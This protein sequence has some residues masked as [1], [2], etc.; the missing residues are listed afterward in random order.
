[1]AYFYID[2]IITVLLF[3]VCYICCVVANCGLPTGWEH[4]G[5]GTGSSFADAGQ[6]RPGHAMCRLRGGLPR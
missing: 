5:A 1:M 2:I 3:H 4:G 6:V